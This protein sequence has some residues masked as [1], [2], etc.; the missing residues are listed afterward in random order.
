MVVDTLA[1]FHGADLAAD[2]AVTV[3]KEAEERGYGDVQR[4]EVDAFGKWAAALGPEGLRRSAAVLIVPTEDG[5]PDRPSFKCVLWAAL[6]S[7][8]HALHGLRYA[9][10]GLGDTAQLGTTWR[11][12]SWA[13]ARDVNQGAQMVDAWLKQIGG[14][15]FY[16][17][18]EA[19]ERTGNEVS[20]R[21]SVR[22]FARAPLP[23]AG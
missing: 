5:Q 6:A 20:S 19:D 14:T 3:C 18:G 9:I 13:S 11:G 10:L 16:A 8:S 7:N 21:T 1:V 17:R 15:R 23:T 2:V 4:L 22:P 12:T